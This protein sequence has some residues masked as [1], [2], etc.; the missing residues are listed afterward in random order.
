MRGRVSRARSLASGI[1]LSPLSI[2]AIFRVDACQLLIALSSLFWVL[3]VEGWRYCTVRVHRV[4]C[5]ERWRMIDCACVRDL[6][7]LGNLSGYTV[8]TTVHGLLH[9][10][11]VSNLNQQ[12]VI[13]CQDCSSQSVQCTVQCATVVGQYS[14]QYSTRGSRFIHSSFVITHVGLLRCCPIQLLH[15]TLLVTYYVCIN[16]MH[17]RKKEKKGNRNYVNRQ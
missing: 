12:W 17:N 11:L 15:Q 9:I 5:L 7:W 10:F 3:A 1:T 2:S 13:T 6:V 8:A 14:V 16:C 4:P